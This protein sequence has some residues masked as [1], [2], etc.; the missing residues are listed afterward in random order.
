MNRLV[1]L[2]M[3]SVTDMDDD[4]AKIYLQTIIDTYG[5]TKE[6]LCQLLKCSMS[7]LGAFIESRNL[8]LMFTYNGSSKTSQCGKSNA[9]KEFMRIRDANWDYHE[10]KEDCF[11][12]AANSCLIL[13]KMFCK[14]EDCVFYKS[15]QQY[16]LDCEKYPLDTN[17]GKKHG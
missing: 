1:P 5:A 11:A 14:S 9:W 3:K 8:P 7:M 6:N 13:T 12:H 10:E 16:E 15:K 4:C 17:Y 2:D